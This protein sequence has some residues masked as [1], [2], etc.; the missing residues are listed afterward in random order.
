[1][2]NLHNSLPTLPRRFP[3]LRLGPVILQPGAQSCLFTPT[4]SPPATKNNTAIPSR[5]KGKNPGAQPHSFCQSPLGY[6][7]WNPLFPL[8]I[9]PQARTRSINWKWKNFKVK[10][11]K[12]NR[13]RGWETWVAQP[14][15]IQLLGTEI[16][17]TWV[18]K[19]K[20][21][22]DVSHIQRCPCFS[23]SLWESRHMSRSTSRPPSQVL[24]QS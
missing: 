5:I 9:P 3:P 4:S 20:I 13:K 24:A 8:C 14:K 7:I 6:A 16:S 21:W 10:K 19:N 11:K 17:G 2:K 23:S 22:D 18:S 1:M 12:K 15:M